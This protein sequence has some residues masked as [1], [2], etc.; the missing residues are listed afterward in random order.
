[1]STYDD[2]VLDHANSNRTRACQMCA[3]R[4]AD[5]MTARLSSDATTNSQ[6]GSFEHVPK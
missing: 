6:F 1:M 4:L 2:V 5:P 3:Y